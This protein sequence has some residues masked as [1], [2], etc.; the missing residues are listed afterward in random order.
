MWACLL[1]AVMFQALPACAQTADY[2]ELARYAGIIFRGTVENV[3]RIAAAAPGEV[4]ILR[5]TFRVQEAARGAGAGQLLT[6]AQWDDASAGAPYRVGQAVVLFLYPPSGEL[7]LTSTVAGPLGQVP[8]E[9]FAIALEAARAARAGETPCGADEPDVPR[10]RK[11]LQH[12]HAVRTAER[13]EA[14]TY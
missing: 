7:G 5:V 14:E 2:P 13:R 4:P 3:E 11:P 8:L 6:I 1:L 10:F 12:G 9:D